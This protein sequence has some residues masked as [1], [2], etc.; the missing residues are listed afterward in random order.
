M[1]ALG[2]EDVR[3]LDVAMNDAFGVSSIES[4][5]DLNGECKKSVVFQG[6]PGHHVLEREAVEKFHRDEALAVVLADFVDGADV[7][8]VQRGSG[9]GFAAKAFESLRILRNVFG[10][11]FERDKATEGGVFGLVNNAHP[12]A[13]QF[14]D[15]AIVRD[16]LADH[17]VGPW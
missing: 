7:G 3:G 13:A 16:G 15:D 1:A 17:A 12:A 14:F 5:G 4:V 9:A 10:E 8:V 2:D 11:E 6:A